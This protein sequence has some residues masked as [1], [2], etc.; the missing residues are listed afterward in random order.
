M[1]RSTRICVRFEAEARLRDRPSPTAEGDVGELL[2]L[3]V[4]SMVEDGV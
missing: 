1:C 4:G 3:S 2:V